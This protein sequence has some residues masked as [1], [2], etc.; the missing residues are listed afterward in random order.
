MV[1]E[2]VKERLRAQHRTLDPVALLAEIRSAQ[3]EL[4]NRIDRRA[5]G[6]LREAVAVKSV[7]VRSS[8]TEPTAWPEGLAMISQVASRVR[9]TD[10][11]SD[12]TR[13]GSGYRQSSTGTL[14]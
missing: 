6:V 10:G 13:N 2:A 4:G 12:V 7:V 11:P 5:G 9:R 1:A 14:R 3:E 8:I